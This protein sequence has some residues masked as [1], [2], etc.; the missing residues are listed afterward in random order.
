MAPVCGK[1]GPDVLPTAAARESFGGIAGAPL[2]TVNT[3]IPFNST[4]DYADFADRRRPPRDSKT[5]PWQV[6]PS[7]YPR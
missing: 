3:A 5:I 1:T 7:S 4:A 6:L 2:G